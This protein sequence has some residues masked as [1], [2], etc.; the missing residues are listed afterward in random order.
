VTS[1]ACHETKSAGSKSPMRASLGNRA[2][3]QSTVSDDAFSASTTS[4]QHAYDYSLR[5]ALE[6][7]IVTLQLKR[8]DME[9]NIQVIEGQIDQIRRTIT[10]LEHPGS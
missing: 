10:V 5:G 9:H 6:E 2:R 1:N 3:P 7:Q 4:A 8:Q